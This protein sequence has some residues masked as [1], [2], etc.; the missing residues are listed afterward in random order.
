MIE[1]ICMETALTESA[2]EVF[3]TMIFMDITETSEQ[4]VDTDQMMLLGSI[5]FKGSLEGCLSICCSGSCARVIAAN[6]LG[7]DSNEQVTPE[8]TYDAIG[9]VANMILGSVKSRL[10]EKV[11]NLEISIPSVISGR[12]IQN[13]LLSKLFVKTSPRCLT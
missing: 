12:E 8:D 5:T 6:M 4:D 10:M 13:S 11:G 7:M 1:Q 3:E 2:K 9:E